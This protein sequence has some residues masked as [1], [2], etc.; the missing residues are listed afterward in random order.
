VDVAEAQRDLAQLEALRPHIA[1]LHTL[2]GRAKDAEMALSSAAIVT[3]L[4]DCALLKA[5]GK[6]FWPGRPVPRQVR[7]LLAQGPRH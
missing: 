7:P 1:S 6:G 2:I 3:A 4:E 5:L